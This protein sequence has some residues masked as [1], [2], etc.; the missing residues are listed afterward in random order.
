MSF[1]RKLQRKS[2]KRAEKRAHEAANAGAW[3]LY[4]SGIPTSVGV[5]RAAAQRRAAQAARTY[6]VHRT[7]RHQS[8]A[9]PTARKQRGSFG[10]PYNS[11]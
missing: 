1:K 7:T 9:N 8:R 11:G 10:I 3:T 4:V 2:E 5:A 6:R